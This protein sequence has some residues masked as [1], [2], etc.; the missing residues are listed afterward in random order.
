MI[1]PFH[2]RC[3]KL[4]TTRHGLGMTELI[5]AATLLITALSL[6]V[7]LSFRTGKLWQDSRHYQ[8]AVQ[9]LTNQ[10]ERLTS[11]DETALDTALTELVVSAAMQN[12]LPNPRLTGKKISDDD[13]TRVLLE[14]NWDRLGT[15][16]PLSLVG[17]IAPPAEA[18]EE[19]P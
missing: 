4:R 6:L 10:Q 3:Q 9:E 11:L 18:A 7:T 19:T 17:W 5:V 14:I 8:L 12:A 15:A 2:N 13:G 1:S 16:H